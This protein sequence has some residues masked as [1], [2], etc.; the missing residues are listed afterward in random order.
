[1]LLMFIYV[2]LIIA[3]VICFC[4]CEISIICADVEFYCLVFGDFC[5]Y[6]S[7]FSVPCMVTRG[8]CGITGL[9]LH[10]GIGFKTHFLKFCHLLI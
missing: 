2:E 9:V 3:S 6:I 4:G 8:Q 10:L 1:M 7:C 5:D